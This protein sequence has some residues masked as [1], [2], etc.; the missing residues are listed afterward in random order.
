MSNILSEILYTVRLQEVVGSTNKKITNIQFDSRLSSENGL[1]IAIKGLQTDGHKYIDKAILKGAVAVVCETLPTNLLEDI[2]YLRVADSQKALATTASNFYGEPSKKIKLVGITGTNGKTT[3]ATLLFKL[4]RSLKY[5]VGLISTIQYQI[6][7]EVFDATHTTPNALRLNQLLAEM[8]EEGCE[9]CFM[10]VSSHA[11]T[12]KRI[13]GIEFAGGIFTNMSHDHV[14]YH[15]SFKAYIEAKK[16]FFDQLPKTAF[17]LVN[18]DDKQGK[19]MLQNT[20][21]ARNTYALKKM[22]D[23]KAKILSND[24]SGLSLNIDEKE[25]HS[26][27]IGEFNAYNLLCVYATARLLGEEAVEVLTVLSAL[28]TAEG[29]FDYVGNINNSIVGIVDYAHTPDALL[30]VLTTIKDIRTNNEQ[31]ITIVGCGGDRDKG[32]RPMMA[33]IACRMSNKIILTS[34]NPR[35]ERA[36]TIIEDMEKGVEAEYS[37]KTLSITN[38]REAIKAACMMAKKGDIILLAGKGHEKYQEIDGV[39]YPFDDKIELEKA[40]KLKATN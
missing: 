29:R 23:F 32:K 34:D 35:T 20:K 7:E 10:E 19:I 5:N 18:L 12:Q 31:V 37:H 8:I 26:L 24:F 4:F 30:K 27:L 15:G 13:E 6:N 33:K 25:V 3:T 2:T 28:K 11:V 22:A 1:F 21:A 14:D 38:R 9:Y 40:L 17:A 16:G 39:K 36:E